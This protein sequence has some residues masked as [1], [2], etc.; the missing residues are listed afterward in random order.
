M[1]A[2]QVSEYSKRNKGTLE[3]LK[4]HR[5]EICVWGS[6]SKMGEMQS[7]P[8]KNAGKGD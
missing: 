4:S 2:I 7:R 5:K 1:D 3:L 6:K 8:I